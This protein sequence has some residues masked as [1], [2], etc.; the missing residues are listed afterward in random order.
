MVAFHWAFD[1]LLE[2]E[3]VAEALTVLAQRLELVLLRVSNYDD[4]T[5]S[6]IVFNDARDATH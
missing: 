3:S 2:A 5:T 6:S 4:P 1:S